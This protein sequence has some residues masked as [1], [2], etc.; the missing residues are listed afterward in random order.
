IKET[1]LRVKYDTSRD[2]KLPEEPVRGDY[3]WLDDGLPAGAKAEAGGGVN[4]PWSFV[5][6]PDPV[7]SG[8]KS[9]KLNAK[10][11]RQVVLTDAKP[12][13]TVGAGDKLFAYVWID[14]K[15]PPREIMVQWFSTNW[16]HRAYWGEN[17]VDFG[18][19]NSTE[20]RKMGALP[21]TGEWVR[22]EV[23]AA[24]VG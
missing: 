24:K 12:G 14:P 9:V 17:L 15:D 7:L 13:L 23:D 3:V 8:D 6:K 4:V 11:L 19:D 5:G 16:L 21:E 1:A 10:G 20:R 2:E 18:A 22:L